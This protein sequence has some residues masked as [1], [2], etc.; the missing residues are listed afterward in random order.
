MVAP[1]PRGAFVL[2]CR[3]AG[4]ALALAALLA[5]GAGHRPWPLLVA[6][7]AMVTLLRVPRAW[8]VVEIAVLFVTLAASLPAGAV[9]A[10]AIGVLLLLPLRPEEGSLPVS[11]VDRYFVIHDYPGFTP[12]SHHV[13]D[14]HEPFDPAV[15]AGAVTLLMERVPMARSFVRESWLSLERFAA[16]RPWVAATDLIVT[17]AGPAEE[18]QDEWLQAPI[19]L[20]RRP[21]FRLL[22]G[23]R[24]GGG[25]RLV[26]TLHHSA[27]DGTAGLLLLDLLLCCYQEV[28]SGASTADLPAPPGAPRLRR[29]LWP[30]GLP[31]MLRMVRRHVRPMDKVGTVNAS[32]LDD[33]APRP[34][35]LRCLTASMSQERMVELA[36]RA[37]AG[38]LTR[39]DLLVTAALRAADGWR[40]ARGKA[41]RL[42]RVLLPTDL[43]GLF[44]LPATLGNMVGVVRSE[45]TAEE[46]RR[47]DLASVVSE[48]VRRGRELEDAI[49]SPVNLGVLSALLPPWLFRR[50]LRK[51]DADPR[52]FFFSFL[53]SNIRIPAGF[54]E[55]AGLEIERLWVRG[56]LPRQPGAGIVAVQDGRQMTL[57]F[58]AMSAMVSEAGMRDFF[59]RLLA[60]LGFEEEAATVKDGG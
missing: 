48:R 37:R 56:S 14:T 31:W 7:W 54:T 50:E 22:V 33:E 29:L 4:A 44:E 12:N 41:D 55:P 45:Y 28:R 51:F 30:R 21:P 49:E 5:V 59:A 57:A 18:W 6:A 10:A 46:T 38:G 36:E 1:D 2:G 58:Y 53:L 15:L 9:G 20:R 39:N 25:H 40:R 52:S 17:R 47:A 43:R 26:F 19:D 35:A 60:E 8:L 16:R 27:G 23:P 24:R 3:S 11:G 42:F 13:L 34:G 32:I